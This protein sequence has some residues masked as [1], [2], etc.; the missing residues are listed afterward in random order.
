M[1]PRT[2]VDGNKVRIDD[3]SYE[4]KPAGKDNYAVFDDFGGRLGYFTVR[5]KVITPE[6]YGV[7]GAHPVVQIGRLWAAAN[8]F[9][10]QDKEAGPR[11]VGVCR[12]AVHERPSPADMDKARAHRAWMKKQTGCKASY[13]VHD[14][15]TGKALSISIWANRGQLAAL[16]SASPPEGAALP[17]TSV[18]IYPF[19][20]DP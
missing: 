9:K 14:P 2:S 3:S 13:F 11:T 18:E 16:G 4:V 17:A 7:D 20:E 10:E 5:G 15:E 1:A 19:V 8:L 6:D 12:I